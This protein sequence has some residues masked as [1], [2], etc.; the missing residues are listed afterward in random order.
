MALN[1]QVEALYNRE[2]E[3]IAATRGGIEDTLAAVMDQVVSD[4]E[5]HRQFM[6]PGNT[7]IG[8]LV[9][10][11]SASWTG[12]AALGEAEF[13]RLAQKQLGPRAAVEYIARYGPGKARQLS[14]T[15]AKQLAQIVVGGQR[16]GKSSTE[17]MRELVNKIP[18]LAAA[19]AKIIAET[20]VHS[21]V[22]FGAYNAALRSGRTLVKRWHTVEDDRVRDFWQGAQF[23]HRMAEGQKKALD[24]A[25]QIP[26]ISGGTEAL[27]FPGDPEGSAGNIINCRCSVTYEEA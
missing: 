9:D 26:H 16:A 27:R 12:G 14:A 22:Q 25:F 20:E 8:L 7:S 5:R 18:K 24:I 10:A 1:P 17:I 21:A 23:S 6:V 19:R 3:L 15:T 11:L 2:S 4:F 13:E